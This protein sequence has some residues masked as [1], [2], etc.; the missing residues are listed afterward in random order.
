MK[1]RIL[2]VDDQPLILSVVKEIL[3]HGISKSFADS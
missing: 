3:S 1:P 2:I